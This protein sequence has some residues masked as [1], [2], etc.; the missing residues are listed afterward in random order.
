MTPLPDRV[1]LLGLVIT[2]GLCFALA[3]WT[4]RLAPPPEG[5]LLWRQ[6]SAPVTAP[7]RRLS[8]GEAI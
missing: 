2:V 4:A 7:Q 3:F 6:P 1:V 8:G 5:P